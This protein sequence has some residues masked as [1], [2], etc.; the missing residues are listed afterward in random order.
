[1]APVKLE[2]SN[3]AKIQA[4]VLIGN[5]KALLYVKNL[6][7]DWYRIVND[8]YHA[9][10]PP[11]REDVSGTIKIHGLSSGI[12]YQ[13]DKW[14]TYEPDK[15][16]QIAET[17]SRMADSSGTIS[18]TVSMDAANYDYAYK[19]Y[20]GGGP[21]TDT[22]A[23]SVPQG[24]TV[25]S[26]T[27]N[28]ISIAWNASTDNVGVTGYRV[29]RD[30]S[31]LI[32]IAA[33]S[34][35]NSGLSPDT[36]YSYA[37]AA[38]DAAGN[39]S[40]HTTPLPVRTA[41]PPD[42][43]PP[44]VP[45]N[46]GS[47]S[48]TDTTVSLAWSAST[49]N[50][51]VA[52]YRL[53]RDDVKIYEG[54]SLACTDSGRTA[55]TTYTYK[56]SAFDAAGN[57]S[58]RSTALA[59]TTNPPPDTIVPSVPQNLRSTSKTYS[60]IS[61][62]WNASTDNV[63]VTG[64]RLYRNN[65]KIYE[66]AT[67]VYTDSGRTAS[68]AY[69]YTVTACDAAG[70]VSGASIPLIVQTNPEPDTTPPTVPQN[71]HVVLKT[72]DSISIAWNASSDKIGV[73][74]YEIYRNNVL[75]ADI[76]NTGYTD[77]GLSADT[78]YNYTVLAYDAAGN[79][80]SK[81]ASV[82]IRTDLVSA[83]VIL[84][85][86]FNDG[87]TDGWTIVNETANLGPSV[88]KVVGG[89][90]V[91][92]ANIGDVGRKG[93]YALYSTS[94]SWTD[95]EVTLRLKST[96]DDNFGLIFRRKD[97]NNFYLFTIDAQNSKLILLKKSNGLFT[98]LGEVAIAGYTK[99]QWS[100]LKVRMAGDHIH[101]FLGGAIVFDE[102]DPSDPILYGGIGLYSCY[103][104]G[105]YFDNVKVLEVSAGNIL[106]DNFN[107]GNSTGWT[108][109]DE[110][111]VS[112]PSKWSV[113]SGALFQSANIGDVGRKGTYA[114]YNGSASW[115][116]YEVT[117]RLKSA[118]DD[119]FGLILRRQDS[120]DFYLF[121]ID[122]QNSKML[123]LKKSNGVFATLSEASLAGYSKNQWSALK[124][125]MAGDHIHVF[126]GGAIVFDEIDPSD[127]ILYGGIGL[128]SCYTQGAYFD[129]VKALGVISED[130]G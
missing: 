88:W 111:I 26:K 95:Y 84:D 30:D 37:V 55:N 36:S 59:V 5:N 72:Y 9:S 112:G 128:Y 71:L 110:T 13:I 117:L 119:N 12:A 47:A 87:K 54:A 115:T 44:S 67:L 126:L 106:E 4:M 17:F 31:A 68:T 22:T 32:N 33:T 20:T 74:G 28:S 29:Y 89:E 100:T 53:Y 125:R 118:D 23:P 34:Y 123:L 120:N 76:T 24:L 50:V 45:Q 27:Y 62:A 21:E 104:Q 93:T 6:T 114:L 16:K 19:I 15:T 51:A 8:P 86:N 73:D 2:C 18:F 40:D 122:D 69:T 63:G 92:S 94:A 10:P 65:V 109:I 98:T 14:K 113:V 46:L 70:N 64:Y 41:P 80:S 56:V 103:A 39:I 101:V 97:I 60:S 130:Q 116:D 43:T 108:I 75:V 82:A 38:Y 35:T 105:A 127:P 25:T 42:I 78:A 52:G 11:T 58:V 91:Q 77:T 102:I 79:K 124:V 90:L 3:T 57:E 85:D 96:D 1:V 107:D 48:K 7:D 61:L 81:C 83:H 49:D 66:G 129:D 121:T 99:G